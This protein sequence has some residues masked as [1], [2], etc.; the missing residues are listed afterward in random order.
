MTF[1]HLRET[2]PPLRHGLLLYLCL[3]H[4]PI[5]AWPS[6]FKSQI[7]RT[8]IYPYIWNWIN[9]H[10]IINVP[11]Q[12]C[13][14]IENGGTCINNMPFFWEQ[15]TTWKSEELDTAPLTCTCESTHKCPKFFIFILAVDYFLSLL[16][17][18]NVFYCIS[19]YKFPTPISY[20]TIYT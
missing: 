6:C 15:T 19:C 4:T 2:L 13:T 10:N 1:V 16:K 18:V 5:K 14:K 7:V 9:L 8:C 20:E 17:I 11:F 12:I 3:T